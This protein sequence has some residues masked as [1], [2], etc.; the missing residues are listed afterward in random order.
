MF[1]VVQWKN[2]RKGLIM[3]KIFLANL[4]KTSRRL[5][6]LKSVNTRFFKKEDIKLYWKLKNI[7][8]TYLQYLRYPHFLSLYSTVYIYITIIRYIIRI[9]VV[10][11]NLFT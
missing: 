10:F 3:R 9:Y 8:L 5:A 6:Q 4:H 2:Y 11:K 7:V 1:S